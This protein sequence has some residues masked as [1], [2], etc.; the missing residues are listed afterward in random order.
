MRG[1]TALA[2]LAA[3]GLTSYSALHRRLYLI[4]RSDFIGRK[5]L[6]KHQVLKP[7]VAPPA[8]LVKIELYCQAAPIRSDELLSANSIIIHRRTEEELRMHDSGVCLSGATLER[9]KSRNR[10][11]VEIR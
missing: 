5:L 1:K 8:R 2:A 10:E 9:N 7:K 4:L 6:E 11:I 3:A